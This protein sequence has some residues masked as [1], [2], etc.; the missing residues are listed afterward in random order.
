[1][2]NFDLKVIEQR[3]LKCAQY[4][5]LEVGTLYQLENQFEIENVHVDLLE[6]YRITRLEIKHLPVNLFNYY[7]FFLLI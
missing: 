5:P 4:W 1:M 7:T 3:R 6:D 2:C